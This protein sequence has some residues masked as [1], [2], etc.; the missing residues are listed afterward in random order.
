MPP[1]FWAACRLFGQNRLSGQS[2]GAY[3]QRALADR[4][5]VSKSTI[6]RVLDRTGWKHVA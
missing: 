4:F 2:P 5:G 6:K 3:T 1:T